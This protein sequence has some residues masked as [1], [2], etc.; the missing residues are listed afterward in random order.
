MYPEFHPYVGPLKSGTRAPYTAV[1]GGSLY[2]SGSIGSSHGKPSRENSKSSFFTDNNQLSS[3][4]GTSLMMAAAAH[5]MRN[6]SSRI[7]AKSNGKG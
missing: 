5:Q 3:K 2:S 4:A 6:S 1:S 7:V